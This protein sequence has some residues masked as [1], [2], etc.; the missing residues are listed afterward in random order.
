MRCVSYIALSF[1]ALSLAGCAATNSGTL[2]ASDMANNLA[3]C[4]LQ[5]DI[6]PKPTDELSPPVA[7]KPVG[8]DPDAPGAGNGNSGNTANFTGGSDTI[9]LEAGIVVTDFGTPSKSRLTRNGATT[10]AKF[11][12][13]TK[14]KNNDLWARAKTMDEY[15]FG[16]TYVDPQLAAVGVTDPALGGT[17]K[18]YRSYIQDSKTPHDELLQ[19]WTFD[20]SYV[21]Q[22]R[23]E[24]SGRDVA[25]K[26]AWSFGTKAGGVQTRASA[27][28]S[29]RATAS[30]T[31]KFG[32]TA[33]TENWLNTE[34]PTQEVNYNNSWRV[35]GR[36][37]GS[38]NFTTSRVSTTLT[39]E[40]WETWADLNGHVGSV[41][42]DANDLTDINNPANL[43][44]TGFMNAQV[45]LSGV[46]TK[47][48]TGNSIKGRSSLN[49]SQ[50]WLSD[51]TTGMFFGSIYGSDADEVTGVFSA[52]GVLPAPA[53]GQ[54]PLANPRRGRLSHSGGFNIRKN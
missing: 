17:Y 7:G 8:S 37:T 22:Y 9:A 10:T 48:S 43:Y 28:P 19:V 42:V 25:D 40:W 26:Q 3:V 1:A 45:R 49:S 14:S 51:G 13:E 32:S 33:I 41:L 11:E 53:G 27:M 36:A 6:G 34:D 30:Y 23:D 47:T 52:S 20:D 24:T 39:P 46:L 2:S 12:I 50:G 15:T 5:C 54:L 35:R 44:G 21:V 18:E 31:G 4:G 38:V 16:S 29:S